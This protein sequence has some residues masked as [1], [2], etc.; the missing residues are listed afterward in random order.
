MT[1]YGKNNPYDGKEDNFQRAT[2]RLLQTK[3]PELWAV[4]FH[5]PNGGKRPTRT[6]PKTGKKYNPEGSKMKKHGTKAGVPDWIILQPFGKWHGLALELK[7]KEG[8][9]KPEQKT[10]L[11]RLS[12]NHYFTAVVWS[13]DGFI[14]AVETYY[15]T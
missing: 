10:F 14:E 12:E 11:Q 9:L 13:L 5:V 4:A 8:T 15:T 6:N 1:E 7:A 2:V 3:Y